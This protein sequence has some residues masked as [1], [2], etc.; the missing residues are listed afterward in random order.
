MSRLRRAL[1]S[2]A[3]AG[4][5][6]HCATPSG[7]EGAAAAGGAGS[8]R[9]AW[10]EGFTVQVS[11]TST[12]TRDDQPA[13]SK[14]ELYTLRLEGKGEERRL[15]TELPM[16][17]PQT[18]TT[19]TDGAPPQTPTLILGPAGELRRMEGIDKVVQE[20][21]QAADAQGIPA[22]QRD[23]I[24]GL[25]RDA[26][27]QSSRS[28]WEA[29]IGKWSG[30]AL[31]PGETVERKGQET[32]PLFGSAVATLERVTLKERVPCTASE[33]EKRCV[34]LVLESS[35]DPEGLVRAKEA[36]EQRVK[37]LVKANAGVAEAAIPARK[38][39]QLRLD[40]TLEFIAEP[41]T[42]IPHHQRSV[43]TTHVVMQEEE[44]ET[45]RF[46]I[47][48]EQVEVFTPSTR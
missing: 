33:T 9:F 6:T 25:V 39:E 2:L 10:P 40:G 4:L 5:L 28:R 17:A 36:L 18:G 8:L 44:G 41:E 43:V 19:G 31:K 47:Q 32:V 46:R 34:R 11:S 30:L 15:I 29:L 45:K 27:E 13:E 21:G 1:T 22:E 26:L 14:A 12:Q 7:A 38:V 20:M 16:M 48:S 37:T 3:L 35:L 23:Q 24:L 42:L